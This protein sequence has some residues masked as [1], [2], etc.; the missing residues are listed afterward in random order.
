M[1]PVPAFYANEIASKL[2]EISQ[3]PWICEN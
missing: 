3:F 1:G 2:K